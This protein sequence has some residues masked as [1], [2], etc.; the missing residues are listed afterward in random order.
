MMSGENPGIMAIGEAIG[1]GG[2]MGIGEAA[3]IHILGEARAASAAAA[4]SASIAGS[5]GI[6]H[7]NPG[8]RFT[9]WSMSDASSSPDMRSLPRVSDAIVADCFGVYAV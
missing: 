1:T 4:L 7:E 5:H 6:A 9:I 8:R 2:T 3:P